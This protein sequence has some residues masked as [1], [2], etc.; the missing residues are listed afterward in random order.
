MIRWPA[1]ALRVMVGALVVALALLS[2]A[3]AGAELPQVTDRNAVLE[4]LARD[5]DERLAY[6]DSQVAAAKVLIEQQQRALA[7]KD[8]EIKAMKEAAKP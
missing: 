5:L 8:A 2:T 4:Q 3:P 1:G 7:A 6:L